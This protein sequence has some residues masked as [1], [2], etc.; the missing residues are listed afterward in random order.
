MKKEGL[1]HSIDQV[2]EQVINTSLV[3]ASLFGALAYSASV[4]SRIIN[5]NLNPS[6]VFESIVFLSL[7]IIT[8]RRKQIVNS[9]KAYIMVSLIIFLSLS[10]AFFYGILL[11]TRVYLVLVPLYAIIYFPFV[12]SLIIYIITLVGFLIIGFHHSRGILQLPSGYEPAFYVL[13]LYPWIINAI[14]ISAVGLIILYV[15]RKFFVAFS[16]LIIDLEDQNI[17][18]SENERNYREIFNSTSEA[19]FIHNASNG[20]INDVNDV[21]LKMY[22]LNSKEEALG[23]SVKDIS[24]SNDIETQEKAQLLIRKAVEEGPQVFEWESKRKNGE[25]FYSEISLKSTE[26]GGE[27]RVLAVVRDISERKRMEQS[28]LESEERYRTLVETSQDGISLMDMTG[29]MLYVNN[30]KAE[31]I[32][33]KSAIELIGQNAFDLLTEESVEEVN[34]L[35]PKL[36]SDGYIDKFEAE[37]RRLN[38]TIFSAEFNVTILKDSKGEPK[39]MMDTMRDITERKMNEKALIESQQ[40]FQTLS[41]MSP[42]GIFRTNHQGHFTYVN[43]KWSELSGLSSEEA[44]GEGWLLS[45]HPDDRESIESKWRICIAERTRFREEFR[46]LKKDG[47]LTWV[48]GIAVPDF[49]NNEFKGFIGTNTNVTKRT[50]AQLALKESEERYR[51]IIEAF[52]EIIMVSDLKGNIIMANNALEKITGITLDDYS[53]PNRKAQ[54][55]PDDNDLVI[56]EIKK[57][58]SSE[59]MH[60]PIIENRF[61][62]AWGKTHWLSGI[63]SKIYINN[64]LYLQTISRDITDKKRVE[65]ELEKYRNHLELLVQ[66]RTEELEAANEELHSTNEELYSQ[67]EELEAALNNLQTAQNKLI[68]S[69]KMASLG[70]LAAGIA[71]EINNPLNFIQGGVSALETYARE[72]LEAKLNDLTPYIEIINDGVI[73]AAQIVKGLNQ[74]SQKSEKHAA[75]CNLHSI[76]NNCLLMLTNQIKGRIIVEKEYTLDPFTISCNEGKMHQAILNILK[77]AVQSI[78]NQGVIKIQTKKTGKNIQV[79]II[80]TGCGISSE[81]LLKIFDPFF[82]TKNP[83]EGTGLGLS[84][85]QNIVQEQGGTIEFESK[86]GKGTKVYLTLPMKS[87]K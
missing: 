21:M 76:I 51:T 82:T 19:I 77:N 26:I 29:V 67:R 80:D 27:G 56:D 40:L 2:K 42:V 57:L 44:L 9:V 55:H 69:E 47:S 64:Q 72:N 1:I 16:E 32:G 62:D 43:P 5:N 20:Q 60:T 4:A 8:I 53:N 54:I 3:V 23:L 14:H 41:Q 84:I 49:V 83:G 86:L 18:I 74:Y 61:I 78:E 13:K 59:S 6:I 52:P 17:K 34:S 63:I 75:S 31:M 7:I 22:G 45:V 11:S 24:A 46:Y 65:E 37:V 36:I 73:R 85:T 33:A 39:Y 58:L 35:M 28:M 15:T 25:L 87:P 66:E 30:K 71:H 38:G 70:V 79:T 48:M 68:Q 12:R 81:N 50:L 10:D